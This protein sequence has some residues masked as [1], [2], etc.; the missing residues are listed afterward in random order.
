MVPVRVRSGQ[1]GTFYDESRSAVRILHEIDACARYV[2]SG[3]M[4]NKNLDSV[5]FEGQIHGIEAIVQLHSDRAAAAATA[6]HEKTDGMVGE[7]L[8]LKYFPDSG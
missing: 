3:F 1:I 5:G 6:G 4:I 2:R 7:I 8:F